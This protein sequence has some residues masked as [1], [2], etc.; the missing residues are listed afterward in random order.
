MDTLLDTIT[1]DNGGVGREKSN[2]SLA[3]VGNRKQLFKPIAFATLSQKREIIMKKGIICIALALLGA[4]CLAM[5]AIA[6]RQSRTFK[7]FDYPGPSSYNAPLGINSKGDI[8]G[9]YTDANGLL[10][11]YVFV[12]GKFK[13]VD[14]PGA[15]M[16]GY[17][18]IND[19]KEVTGTYF[20]FLGF[21]H[22]FLLK[23]GNF[24]SIDVPSAVQTTGII[25]ELGPGLG[26]AAFGINSNGDVVGQYADASGASHGFRLHDGKFKTITHPNALQLP[27]LGTNIFNI[28]DDDVIVGVYY[29]PTLPFAHGFKVENN[30]FT[31]VDFPSAGGTFGTQANGINNSNEIV[32]FYT[33]T[34]DSGHG[35]LLRNGKYVAIDF[36]ASLFTECHCINDNGVITGLYYDF[37]GIAHGFVSVPHNGDDD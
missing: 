14:Y 26:T 7:T 8:A 4:A 35:F 12:D 32:G 28:N 10:H 30:K 16:T 5:P 2:L 19:E 24:R 18:G 6:Q 27:G 25:Y 13:K 20:D 36:P 1:C 9:F 33:D 3:R 23:N 15:L 11:G 21:Q 29:T 31:P 22:G 34:I 17:G 37:L